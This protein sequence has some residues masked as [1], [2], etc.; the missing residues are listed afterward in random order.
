[1]LIRASKRLAPY[2]SWRMINLRK[3]RDLDLAVASAS[4]RPPHLSAASGLVCLNSFTYVI[5]DD[6]LH[7]AV[8]RT[9]TA[10]PGHLIRL[11]EGTLPG[12]AS[13]RKRQ[14]PDLEALSLLPP[15]MD[16]H[17]G[18]LLILGSGSR[19]NRRTGAIIGLDAQGA[20]QGSPQVVDLSAIFDALDG[21]YQS[22]Y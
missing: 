19:P 6:E 17:H 14:K 16:Y 7:L 10:E 22:S 18:A 5:A 3:V 20:T 21:L 12:S 15:S 11:F 9:D 2:R 13:A 4:G 8:F 1:M